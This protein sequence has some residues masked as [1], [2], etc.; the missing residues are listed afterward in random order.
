MF[1]GGCLYKVNFE[2]NMKTLFRRSLTT[3]MCIGTLIA[4]TQ[5]WAAC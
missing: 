3:L 4:G 5:S 1:G 2:Q